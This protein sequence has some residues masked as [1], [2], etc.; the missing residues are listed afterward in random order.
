MLHQLHTHLVSLLF[1]EENLAVDDTCPTN[2]YPFDLVSLSPGVYPKETTGE[3]KTYA[4]TVCTSRV[5]SELSGAS[6]LI[7][8]VTS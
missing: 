6:R 7:S 1:L 5:C 3:L 2:V 4:N 8:H